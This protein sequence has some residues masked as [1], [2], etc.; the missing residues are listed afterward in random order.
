MIRRELVGRLCEDWEDAGWD[1]CEG[2]V[3]LG[4]KMELQFDARVRKVWNLS[5]SPSY[6]IPSP[7]SSINRHYS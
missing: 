4:T 6:S 7:L 2:T 1:A 3:G 5:E